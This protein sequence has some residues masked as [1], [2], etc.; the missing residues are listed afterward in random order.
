MKDY[1]EVQVSTTI[2]VFIILSIIILGTVIFFMGVQVGKKQSELAAQSL[3]ATRTEEKVNQDKP[4]TPTEETAITPVQTPALN[5]S[6]SPAKAVRSDTAGAPEVSAPQTRDSRPTSPPISGTGSAV[7]A[8]KSVA[9]ATTSAE[10]P[11]SSPAQSSGGSYFIQVGAFND[12]SSARLAADRF[13]KQG[14]KTVVKDPYPS[15]RRPVYRVW[16]G[17]YATRE[18]ARKVMDEIA[19]KSVKNPGYFVVHQ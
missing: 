17:G 7:Q 10:K 8:E 2:L 12:L 5:P 16:V 19:K 4:V 14:Y 13:N 9:P 11:V 1:R 3:M 6:E 18:E 15:D